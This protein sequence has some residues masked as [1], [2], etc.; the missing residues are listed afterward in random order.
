MDLEFKGPAFT[1]TN[2]QVGSNNVKERIDRAVAT[3]D[4]R[5]MFPFALVFQDIFIG[6]DHCPLILNSCI[7][8]N[9]VP[10]LFKFESMWIT[11]PNCHTV[12]AYHWQTQMSG[13]P[14]Y[15]LNQKLKEGR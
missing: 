13:S 3:V 1:W 8:P 14:M 4:W 5:E 12:I 6:S 9:R 2:N 10:R 15:Q 11:S 7:P